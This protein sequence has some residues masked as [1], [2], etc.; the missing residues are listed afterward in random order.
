[1]ELI[2]NVKV[3]LPFNLEFIERE[4]SF[5]SLG[6]NT[7]SFFSYIDEFELNR[8]SFYVPPRRAPILIPVFAEQDSSDE[9]CCCCVDDDDEEKDVGLE[10]KVLV[11]TRIGSCRR[12]CLL[13]V[14]NGQ[15][16]VV[17]GEE[18]NVEIFIRLSGNMISSVDIRHCLFDE[19]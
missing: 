7:K 1:M 11:V 12:C 16:D 17:V 15:M 3:H 18:L 8:L 5:F 9:S 6:E 2:R 4:K 19:Y 13:L 14:N 10:N